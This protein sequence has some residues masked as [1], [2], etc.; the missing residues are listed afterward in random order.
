MSAGD[1]LT[2]VGVQYEYMG[3][4]FGSGTNNIVAEIT[5]LDSMPELVTED[6]QRTDTHGAS[7]GT[8]LMASREIV[9]TLNAV[10]DNVFGNDRHAQILS[11]YR[12]LARVMTPRDDRVQFCFQ[13]PGEDAKQLWVR[14]R[15]RDLPNTGDVATGL[16]VG[17]L[18]WVAPDPR[19]YS[20][21]QHSASITLPIGVASNSF[22]V[23]NLGDFYSDPIVTITGAGA[24]PRITNG[25]VSR[26]VAFDLAQGS[27]QTLAFDFGLRTAKLDGTSVYSA[28][29]TDNQWWS[30]EPGENTIAFNRSVTTAA[31]TF[32]IFWYDAWI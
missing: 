20:L 25:A 7:E 3:I 5:G 29:R 27:G 2:G 10:R 8:D 26:T 12:D 22:I 1:L 23:D 19:I 21:E 30:L 15:R 32:T 16:S 14:P 11:F 4:L 18:A 9:M 6:V 28:R 24:N 31:Q 17:S 13:N